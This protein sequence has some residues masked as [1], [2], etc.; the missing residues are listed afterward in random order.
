MR[1]KTEAV[2]RKANGRDVATNKAR[3]RRRFLGDEDAW[4]S[5]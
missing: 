5:V 2:C 3:K 4:S 1:A